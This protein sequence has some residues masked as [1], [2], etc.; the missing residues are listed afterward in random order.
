MRERGKN[1]LMWSL[2]TQICFHLKTTPPPHSIFNFFLIFLA[3]ILKRERLRRKR[4]ATSDTAVQ[5]KYSG[6]LTQKLLA[7]INGE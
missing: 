2:K 4:S 3:R 1:S 6:L 7:A 5:K